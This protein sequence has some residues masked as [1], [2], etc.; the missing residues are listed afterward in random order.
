MPATIIPFT[1][2]TALL[3][4]AE[5]RD[6]S[7]AR[8]AKRTRVRSFDEPETRLWKACARQPSRCQIIIELIIFAIFVVIAL[9]PIA[10]FFEVKQRTDAIEQA[11]VEAQSGRLVEMP[12]QS[13]P[14]SSH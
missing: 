11:A 13:V 12:R 10:C 1:S 9:A 2:A 8:K 5:Q 3:G 4:P 14:R 6:S 7:R